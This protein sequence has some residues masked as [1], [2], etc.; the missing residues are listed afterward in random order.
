[1]VS[2]RSS[3]VLFRSYQGFL[4]LAR[5]RALLTGALLSQV[6]RGL[7]LGIK[8]WWGKGGSRSSQYAVEDSG[9]AGKSK[10]ISGSLGSNSSGV[11]STCLTQQNSRSIF[12]GLNS[13][14]TAKVVSS[15]LGN[16]SLGGLGSFMVHF[17]TTGDWGRGA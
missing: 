4:L 1:M 7:L 15:D 11:G 13:S 3:L 17:D 10:I 14:G 2:R 6:L 5:V 8:F 16:N 12:Y 9:S